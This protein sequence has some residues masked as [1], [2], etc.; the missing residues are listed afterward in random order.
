MNTSL[1][2]IIFGSVAGIYASIVLLHLSKRSA[3]AV[4]LYTFQSLLVVVLL[5]S[6]LVSNFSVLLCIAVLAVLIVKVFVAPRFFYQLI[7]RHE[8]MFSASTYLNGPLT[9]IA[10]ALLTAFTRAQYFQ[11]LTTLSPSNADAILLT[12]STML[13]S[14][15]LI[16]NRKGALSQM[17]GILSLEN[18]IVAFAAVTGLEQTPAL[19]IGVVFDIFIWIMI[20]TVFASMIYQKFG[21]LDVA[22]L[23]HLTEE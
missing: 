14:V 20:A 4:G 22:S 12:F 11:P 1:S 21:S 9:L 10:T 19:E 18:A 5:S 8:V 16:I 3:W 15:F 6:A 13:L 7:Q 17:V 2:Q 23:T